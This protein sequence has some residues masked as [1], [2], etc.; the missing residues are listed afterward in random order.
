MS[1]NLLQGETQFTTKS[2]LIH[3]TCL[4]FNQPSGMREYLGKWGE[5]KVSGTFTRTSSAQKRC[6]VN[7]QPNGTVKNVIGTKKGENTLRLGS[8][9]RTGSIQQKRFVGSTQLTR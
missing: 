8:L 5:M 6:A 1:S 3:S 7:L 4:I 9:S 2:F